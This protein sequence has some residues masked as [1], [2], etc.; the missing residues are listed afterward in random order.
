MRKFLIVSFLLILIFGVK[1]F[2]AEV[3]YENR[4]QT[5]L[6]KNVTYELNRQITTDGMLDIHVLTVPLNNPHM[7]V[8]PV[9]SAHELGRK[10]SALD[11]LSDAG[12]LAG[13]NGDF[14]GMAG[15]YSVPFG[16]VIADGQV[17]AV[18]ATTNQTKNEF[19]AFMLRA[20]NVPILNYLRAEI[21]FYNNGQ[22]NMEIGTYNKTGLD[23]EWPVIIDKQYMFDTALLD[24]RFPGLWKIVVD[25]QRI[26]YISQ[27]GETVQ[28][29]DG[30]YIIVIPERLYSSYRFKYNVGDSALFRLGNN[31]VISLS[32]LRS[33]IGGGGL[34]LTN[35]ETVHDTGTAIAGRQPRTAVGV[36]QDKTRLI[37]M[38]VDGRSHSVGATHDELAA[39][40]S[41]YGAWDAMHL[42][43]GGSSTMVY[44][45][46]DSDEYV[47][48]NTPSDG[49]QR[50]I[51]NTLGVFDRSPV[52]ETVSFDVYL[53]QNRV[54]AGT[55]IIAEP[56][57]R[58]QYGHRVPLPP[59]AESYIYAEPAAGGRWDGYYYTPLMSGQQTVQMLYNGQNAWQYLWV[60]DIAE[61]QSSVNTIRTLPGISTPVTF[62]GVATDGTEV[63]ADNG[64]KVRI[65]PEN[66]GTWADGQF[67]AASPGVGY[68]ECSVGAVSTYIKLTVG[69]FAQPLYAFESMRASFLGYP[70]GV[71]GTVLPAAV[72]GGDGQ[73]QTV[74]YMSYYF[75]SSGATQA[76]YMVFDPPLALPGSPMALQF[77][78]LGD[79][80]GHWLRGRVTDA[81]GTEFT[82]DF[83]RSLEAAEWHT[84]T[85]IIPE[86][87]QAPVVLNRI[88]LAATET[89]A[90]T[91]STVYF[92]GL[93]ALF[94]PGIAVQIPER[95]TFADPMR[96]QGEIPADALTVST[97]VTGYTAQ[98]SG[99]I[100][101]ITLTASKGG[102][103]AT[104]RQQWAS[105]APDIDAY[106]PD[107]IVVVLDINPLN[108]SQ[109]KE[110][111][112]FET[113]LSYQRNM[114]NR[115]VFV[116]SATGTETK[117]TMREG[118]RYIDL[119][120]GTANIKIWTDGVKFY[121]GE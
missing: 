102:I 108:F 76:A 31:I 60:Y 90:V 49:A 48:A 15:M 30:G 21:H 12:A 65:I 116:V 73:Q 66:L 86:E 54:F 93:S 118:I 63:P 69:G 35:G 101:V 13:V 9:S 100:A 33:A 89:A 43:G 64:V 115:P 14:F 96:I 28:I 53:S 99:N 11:M 85:A 3:I 17:R 97:A 112:L 71:S 5:V 75:P 22:E 10:E 79:G 16:P 51:I 106:A 40:L 23:L 84:V 39:L 25:N 77:N 119:P 32:Q 92:S 56:I 27:L 95:Q 74:T 47:V 38:T 82:I 55:P 4:K 36:S 67:T 111:E 121:W 114:L 52:G 105:F 41:R 113:I 24:E 72:T 19:A 68:L 6:A 45:Q 91:S 7:Y 98:S 18:S 59:G 29:P 44:K 1:S 80:T 20:D 50:R 2:A 46:P 103:M 70:A 61:L 62:S 83:E 42:D 110:L 109:K 87:A 78:V 120:Q 104:E 88:Y 58:D 34:I 37:L 94:D 107:A 117:L 8:G 57:G 81:A 26:S